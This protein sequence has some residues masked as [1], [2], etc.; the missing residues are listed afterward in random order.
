METGTPLEA[1]DEE[2]EVEQA[3]HELMARYG[4]RAAAIARGRAMLAGN[5]GDEQTWLDVADAIEADE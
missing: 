5:A 3:A 4:R 1:L 2:I